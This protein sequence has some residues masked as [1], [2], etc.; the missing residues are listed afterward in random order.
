MITGLLFRLSHVLYILLERV[1]QHVL[2]G[3]AGKQAC[4]RKDGG[5]GK[6]GQG[7]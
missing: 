4:D 5:S 3:E 1:L 7:E 2:V 6:R